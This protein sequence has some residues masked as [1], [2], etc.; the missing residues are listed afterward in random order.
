[1]MPEDWLKI[2]QILSK[3]IW[4]TSKEISEKMNGPMGRINRNL[5]Q[6]NQRLNCL[7]VRARIPYRHREWRKK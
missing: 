1:M 5:L 7:E 3:D 6:M 2:L 4:M